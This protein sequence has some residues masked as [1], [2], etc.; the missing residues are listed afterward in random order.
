MKKTFLG[1]LIGLVLPVTTYS[2]DSLTVTLP[3]TPEQVETLKEL[4]KLGLS[5]QMPD[6]AT[7]SKY[8]GLGK[9]IGLAVGS[10]LSAVNKEVAA[11]GDSRVGQW[12]MVIVAWKI[13]GE[14]VVG[15]TQAVFG[16]LIGVPL[17]VAFNWIWLILWSRNT[18]KQRQLVSEE[19]RLKKYEYVDTWYTKCSSDNADSDNLTTAQIFAIA[20]WV[21]YCIGNVWLIAGVIF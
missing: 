14:D 15:F 4:Q 8:S 13:L 11:F 3:F 16:V 19:G 5:V 6:S 21:S 18:R 9:E 7:Q 10:S 20:W 12:T 17:L 1:L 2:Q